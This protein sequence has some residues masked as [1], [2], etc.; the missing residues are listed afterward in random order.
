MN[1]FE[2]VS[3]SRRPSAFT[4][5][6]LLVVIA[7]IAILAALLLPALGAAKRR[8]YNVNCTSNLKQVATVMQMF[9]D[10]Q[11]GY[12]PNGENGVNAG[13][14]MSIAQKAT[15]S[16]ADGPNYY[17]WLVYSIQPYVGGHAPE[18]GPIAPPIVTT[19][20]MKIMY[21]PSNEHYNTAN[22]PSFFSYEMAEGGGAGSVS[23]Y[24][25]L[26]WDPFGYNQSG[27]SPP[28]KL[29]DLG[30]VGSIAQIW[31]M[32]DSDRWGNSGAGAAGSFPPVPAHGSTR[33]YLWFDWHVEPV[34][35]PPYG[36]PGQSD[37][38]HQAPFYG[39]KQ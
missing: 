3:H 35:V 1:R 7:I 18:M 33:N 37:S 28:R 14:G 21:C 10:D 26:P 38:T 32:V 11:N 29:S 13:R 34:K 6:E 17:D 22:N 5:I 20:T 12:L 36:V 24:C 8:A 27:A 31:A 2:N 30:R 9:S 25:G 4:L 39:W 16:Y 15:Y 23:R 19:Y